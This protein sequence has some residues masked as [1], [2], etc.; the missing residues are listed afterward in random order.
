MDITALMLAERAKLVERLAR[1]EYEFEKAH[2]PEGGLRAKKNGDYFKYYQLIE[3]PSGTKWKYIKKSNQGL[4]KELAMKSY[5]KRVIYGIEREIKAIDEYLEYYPKQTAD[6]LF[7]TA[8]GFRALLEPQVIPD[9]SCEGWEKEPYDQST[10]HPEHL[11]FPTMKGHLV[12][13]KSEAMIADELY[14]RGIPYRYEW[15]RMFGGQLLSPDF[16]I[17]DPKTKDI[18]IWEHYG[19]MDDPDYVEKYLR[20]MQI[21]TRNGYIETMNLICTYE[22]KDCPLTSIKAVDVIE[23]YFVNHY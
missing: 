19:K 20:K 15:V 11:V 21:Y 6:E 3:T 18:R 14:R 12:R 23:H 22:T 7:R 1:E 5:K 17:L 2:Y 10:D 13:S 8:P 9:N 16:T 4:A